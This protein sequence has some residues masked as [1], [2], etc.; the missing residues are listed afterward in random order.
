MVSSCG[1]LAPINAAHCKFLIRELIDYPLAFSCVNQ[2]MVNV[3]AAM[4]T[5]SG[6]NRNLT[7]P[8]NGV[9]GL[10]GCRAKGRDHA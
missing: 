4:L 3:V 6:L 9:M 10:R 2:P 1:Q 5:R 7:E 8:L